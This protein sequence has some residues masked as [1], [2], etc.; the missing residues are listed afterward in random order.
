MRKLQIG[1]CSIETEW[2]EK[3]KDMIENSMQALKD[4]V[5]IHRFENASELWGW[6]KRNILHIVFVD[7]EEDGEKGIQLA[8]KINQEWPFC[9]IV[10][11]S[12]NFQHVMDVYETKHIYYI[13]KE[14][15]E[16]K[17]PCVVDKAIRQLRAN[18][19]KEIV[20]QCH[21]GVIVSLY[22]NEIMYFERNLRVTYVVAKNSRYIIDEK[23]SELEEKI[24]S[25]DFLRCHSSFLVNLS[26]V[27]E[28]MKKKLILKNGQ[29]I[30]ISRSYWGK[31]EKEYIQWA[32]STAV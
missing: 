21:G 30:D 9:Q 14:K 6:V 27:K 11:V 25:E 28:C 13:L 4:H 32:K 24:M 8:K 5:E 18:H 23:I 10:Y 15:F 26:Y 7:V 16:E 29:V 22:L 2:L 3:S 19:N 17:L 1:I 12:N 31:V 20:F